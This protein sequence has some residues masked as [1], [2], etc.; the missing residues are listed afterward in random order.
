MKRWRN[1]LR[2]AAIAL[3]ALMTAS[4]LAFGLV[5]WTFPF[6]QEKLQSYPA[7]RVVLDRDGNELRAARH[8]ADVLCRPIRFEETGPWVVPAL[9]AVEDKRFYSH[10]GVDPLAVGRALWQDITARRIVSGASTITMQVVRLIEPRPRTVR[11]KLIESFRALQLERPLTKRQVLEQYLNRAPFGSDLVGIEAASRRYFDKPASEL[12]LSEA[13]LLVGLPQS[14]S[15]LRPD[16]YPERA[17]QRRNV[18]LARMHACGFIDSSQRENARR[19]DIR[20]V[21]R[22]GE[23]RAPHFSELVLARYPSRDPLRTTLDERLQRI[24][25]ESLRRHSGRLK[26]DG[27]F[28]G[29]IVIIDVRAAAVCAMVGS[30]EFWDEAHDGQVNGA[31]SRRSPGSALKPFVYAVAFDRGYCTPATVIGDVPMTFRGYRPE[32]FDRE[33]LGLVTVRD[34]LASSLNI[35]ALRAAEQVGPQN[36][37]AMLRAAGLSTMGRPASH[38][39]LGIA[40]GNCEVTLLNLANAYAALARLGE[41][42]PARLLEDSPLGEPRGVCSPEAA[43]LIVDILSG[44]ERSLEARGHIADARLP[45]VAWKTGTSTGF[46]DAWTLAYNPEF[47]VGVW[48]GNHDGRG[49]PALVGADAAAPLAHELFRR[50]YPDGNAP[51]FQRPVGVSTRVVC[52]RSG[53][54]AGK[55]CGATIFDFHIPGVSAT[56]T[57][58]VHQR[59]AGWRVRERWPPEIESFLQTTR[60]PERI[61]TRAGAGCI[62]I[63]APKSGEVFSRVDSFE[64]VPQEIALSAIADPTGGSLYWF[65]DGELL[66]VCG[67]GERLFWPLSAGQHEIVCG[68]D[69]GRADRV[70]I[71]VD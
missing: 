55:D 34:A 64:H 4:G 21:E 35:P 14:P 45:R 13:A 22:R 48:L 49:S 47:V 9:V 66:G 36:V 58:S 32:N 71:R 6:P 41:Y 52:A 69:R 3:S 39:G 12:S 46:R 28:N 61:R 57:C 56:A 62:R 51:W 50:L 59:D 10:H 65:V 15:R 63:T 29:A 8:D 60:K 38:Y 70:E 27:V 19:Q 33:F 53:Q 24:A 67:S 16:R 30:P 11:A 25:E 40:L 37:L 54:P 31:T 7:A 23:I 44:D 26:M 18:V 43:Y 1:R 5:W 68:D 20:C 42:R 2:R 17:R